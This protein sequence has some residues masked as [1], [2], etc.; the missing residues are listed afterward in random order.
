MARLSPVQAV[1]EHGRQ[2][3][4][5]WLRA[6]ATLAGERVLVIDDAWVSGGSAQSAAVAL[7]LAGAT[8]VAVVVLGRYVSR[9]SRC[10]ADLL[11]ALA[12]P[13]SPHDAYCA[14]MPLSSPALCELQAGRK[15]TTC[16][17]CRYSAFIGG[18]PDIRN[19]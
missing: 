19:N 8:R 18:I 12:V 9:E 7:R 11:A 16:L 13:G 17:P 1:P 10:P 6:D 3:S 15:L 5:G 2:V 4:A 14:D